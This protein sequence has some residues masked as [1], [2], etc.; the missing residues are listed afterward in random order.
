MSYEVSL[1]PRRGS[2]IVWRTEPPRCIVAFAYE[3]VGWLCAGLLWLEFA[4]D[5]TRIEAIVAEAAEAIARASEALPA[6]AA[7]PSLRL[8]PAPRALQRLH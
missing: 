5:A 3:P 7:M 8:A 2:A 4:P 6:A 1:Y